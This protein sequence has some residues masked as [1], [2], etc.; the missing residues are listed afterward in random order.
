MMFTVAQSL[1][2]YLF[3]TFFE[4]RND[5]GTNNRAQQAKLALEKHWVTHDPYF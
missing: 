2:T 5:M 1:V 3:S 4:S